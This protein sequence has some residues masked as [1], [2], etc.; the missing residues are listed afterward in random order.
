MTSLGTSC[1][2]G[3]ISGKYR[4]PVADGA[5]YTTNQ[6]CTSDK[7]ATSALASQRRRPR[8]IAALYNM[9]SRQ[10]TGRVTLPFSLLT[11]GL[12]GANSPFHYAPVPLQKQLEPKFTRPF[13]FCLG[14]IHFPRSE[15]KPP[16]EAPPAGSDL[17]SLLRQ[18]TSPIKAPKEQGRYEHKTNPVATCPG[19][20][21]NQQRQSTSHG[22]GFKSPRKACSGQKDAAQL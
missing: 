6:L 16:P 21:A 3:Q 10:Y 11:L 2:A 4:F 9:P 12:C 7:P 13:C 20:R 8:S 22:P 17:I 15:Q 5:Q 1:R 14:C 18:R 19:D